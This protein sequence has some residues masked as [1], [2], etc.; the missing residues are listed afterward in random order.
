M[1]SLRSAREVALMRKAGSTVAYVLNRIDKYIKPGVSTLELDEIIDGMI[2]SRGCTPNFKGYEGYP[3]SSCISVNEVLVHG[4]PSASIILKEGDVVSVDVGADYQGYQG[5][6]AWTFLVGETKDERV[7]Q[8]LE[9]SEKALYLGLEEI[10]PGKR[11]GDIAHAIQSYV[12]SF[13][14]SL[15]DEYTG[16]GIG[17]DMHEDP[18]VPNK[19]LPHTLEVLRKGMCICVEPM[20]FIGKKHCKTLS[21][22]WTVVS[23]DKSWAAHYEHEIY[24]ND[25]GYEILTKEEA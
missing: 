14:F 16:H 1:I 8:L 20:V 23:R 4:I 10:K 21:D 18:I 15:P 13:G 5:D 11:I 22:G 7:K 3:R 25:D 19:G 9:V 6:G 2:R 12:E 17:R 24:I